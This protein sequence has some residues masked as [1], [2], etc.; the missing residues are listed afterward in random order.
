MIGRLFNLI[1][2]AALAAVI[3]RAVLSPAKRREL[4]QLFQTVSIALLLSAL[5]LAGLVLGG[6]ISR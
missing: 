2:L 5:L 1:L 4:H 3:L 6:W